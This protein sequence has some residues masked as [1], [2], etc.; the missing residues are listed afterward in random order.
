VASAEAQGG[1]LV[2]R[3]GCP[4][5]WGDV[6]A[7]LENMIDLLGILA[8]DADPDVANKATSELVD[9]IDPLVPAVPR[10]RDRLA[11][12]VAALPEAGLM[13][14]RTQITHLEALFDRI[15]DNTDNDLEA[16]K[17]GLGRV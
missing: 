8:H 13:A 14:A 2:E 7:Y 3:R 4:A 5:T 15:G 16:R 12:V 17:Q 10:V 11:A 9:A 1:V 6:Y